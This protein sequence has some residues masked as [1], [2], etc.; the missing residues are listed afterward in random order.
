MKIP[1]ARA[2]GKNVHLTKKMKKPDLHKAVVAEFLQI[3]H[4]IVIISVSTFI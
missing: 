1:S 4:Y 2:L 3:F